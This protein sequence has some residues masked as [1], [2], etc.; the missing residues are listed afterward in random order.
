MREQSLQSKL[1]NYL[2]KS[3]C[4]AVKVVQANK[5]GVPDIICCYKGYFIAFEVKTTET[6]TR[7]SKLQDYNIKQI[8]KCGGLAYVV[9]CIEDIKQTLAKF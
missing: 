5:A 1:L 2:K 3:G 9:T 4:Y 7:T 8:Q 6:A